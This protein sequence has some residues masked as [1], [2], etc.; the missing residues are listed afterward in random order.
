MFRAYILGL[1]PYIYLLFTMLKTLVAA[2]V[3]AAFFHPLPA[4]AD[5]KTLGADLSGNQWFI[6]DNYVLLD[7]TEVG[8]DASFMIKGMRK[9]KPNEVLAIGYWHVNCRSGNLYPL[10]VYAR[11]ESDALTMID[12]IM[13]SRKIIAEK[14]VTNVCYSLNPGPVEKEDLLI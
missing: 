9:D 10:E 14:I 11:N 6:K 7:S 2:S 5:W 4:L 8:I 12:S 1:I 13:V 3:I